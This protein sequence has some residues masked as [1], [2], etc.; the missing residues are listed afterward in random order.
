M[1][2]LIARTWWML[3]ISSDN[4]DIG[5]I[6]ITIKYFRWIWLLL[7][8]HF[9]NKT[10]KWNLISETINEQFNLWSRIT[11]YLITW[12]KF[13]LG[14]CFY[15]HSHFSLLFSKSKNNFFLPHYAVS[16]IIK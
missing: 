14:K 3:N 9:F 8:S 13:F 4:D 2:D 6:K 15:F 12:I 1:I 11:K 5:V 16:Y 7:T 10:I